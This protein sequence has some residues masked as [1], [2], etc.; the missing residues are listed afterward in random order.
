MARPLSIDHVAR[1]RDD[2]TR[3]TLGEQ[4]VDRVQLGLD[5]QAA[6]DS[7]GIS[8]QTLHNWRLAGARARAKAATT[9]DGKLTPSEARL[10]AFVDALERAEAEPA[11]N[12]LAI[13]QRAATGGTVVTKTTVKTDASGALIE[14]TVLTETLRPEWQAAAWWLERRRGYVRRYEVTGAD[15]QALVPPADAARGLADSL[16]DFLQGAAA[17]TELAAK[18]PPKRARKAKGKVID[19]TATDA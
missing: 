5:L 17:A 6:A 9:P 4:V 1:V 12:R 8:R 14:R 13:I 11:P 3:V 16:R 19:T 18:P 15:G 10:A 7:A 2:G